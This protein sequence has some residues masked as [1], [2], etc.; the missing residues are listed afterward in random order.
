MNA[1]AVIIGVTTTSTVAA[2]A[3]AATLHGTDRLLVRAQVFSYF[4]AAQSNWY[5]A[6]TGKTRPSPCRLGS[7]S[8]GGSQMKGYAIRGITDEVMREVVRAQSLHA[9][10]GNAHE[11]YAVILEEL[12]EYKAHVWTKQSQHNQREM[13]K[14][15]IQV[16]AMAVRAIID[17]VPPKPA[18]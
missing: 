17:T 12:D 6:S 2:C 5:S 15:L 3:A 11:A 7:R 18:G 1:A 16:A 9:P 13:R 4:T 14:E 8:D 10:M